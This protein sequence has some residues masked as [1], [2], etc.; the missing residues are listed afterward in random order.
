MIIAA[1]L[2]LAGGLGLVGIAVVFALFMGEVGDKMDQQ[3]QAQIQQQQLQAQKGLPPGAPPPPPVARPPFQ[4]KTFMQIY[5]AMYG[6]WGGILFAMSVVMLIGAIRMK[7]LG[8]YGWAMTGTIT[9][10][11]S[12]VACNLLAMGFGIWALVVLMQP[13]VKEAFE[14]VADPGPR[15]RFDREEDEEWR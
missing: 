4:F 12:V 5:G 8:S 9:A 10:V 14:R 6:I 2:G 3:M 15:R 11:A 1:A 7:T 13:D